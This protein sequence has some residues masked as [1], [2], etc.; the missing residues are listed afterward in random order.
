MYYPEKKR[1]LGKLPKIYREAFLDTTLVIDGTRNSTVLLCLAARE[2]EVLHAIEILNYVLK[3]LEYKK[4]QLQDGQ[5]S[6]C[7]SF[8]LVNRINL[9]YF[10]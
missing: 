7:R 10:D 6:K 5:L 1:H 8:R 2:F 4:I 3:S 9:V